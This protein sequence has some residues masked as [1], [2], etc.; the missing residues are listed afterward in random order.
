MNNVA[1]SG[2]PSHASRVGAWESSASELKNSAAC[3][4]RSQD[5][6]SL[7]PWCSGRNSGISH[8]F[9]SN[10]ANRDPRDSSDH[11]PTD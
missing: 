4:P 9:W 10:F 5:Y 7:T 11:C 6:W 8:G 3:P 2:A 1:G